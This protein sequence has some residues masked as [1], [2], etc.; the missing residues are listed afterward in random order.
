MFP[1]LSSASF[2]GTKP[3]L[4]ATNQSVFR[5]PIVSGREHHNTLISGLSIRILSTIVSSST[6]CLMPM[7]N[8]KTRIGDQIS[9]PSVYLALSRSTLKR[10]PMSRQYQG[11]R[12]GFGNYAA[13]CSKILSWR[14][15]SMRDRPPCFGSSGSQA[16]TSRQG[17]YSGGGSAIDLL[18]DTLPRRE[19]LDASRCCSIF[20]R[21]AVAC[22]S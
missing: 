5:R 9:S 19:G 18:K 2:V 4:R 15:A 11:L 3:L 6:N 22:A 7:L 8:L 17:R 10:R 14:S 1:G 12:M 21:A 13:G 16:K 20:K